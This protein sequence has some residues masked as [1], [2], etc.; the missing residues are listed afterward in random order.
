MSSDRTCVGLKPFNTFKTCSLNCVYCQLGITRRRTV[1]RRAF[2]DTKT[3]LNQI[4]KIISSGQRI[5]YITFSGSGEPTLN[6]SMGKLIREIKKT[7]PIPVAVLT[8]STFLSRKSVRDALSPADLVIPSLDAATQR[9]FARM[10]R[11]HPSLEIHRITCLS[12][13]PNG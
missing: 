1:R 12:A 8:N 10:N 13:K 2:Y 3:I 4:K 11:P 9:I 5:D 6:A 7:T